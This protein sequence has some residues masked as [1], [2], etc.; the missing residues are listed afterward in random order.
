MTKVVMIPTLLQIVA[1]RSEMYDIISE[2]PI[3]H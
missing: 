2:S 1:H 3:L